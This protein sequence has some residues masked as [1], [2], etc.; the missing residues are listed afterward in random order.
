M[1]ITLNL[2]KDHLKLIPFILIKD[3]KDEV[4][5]IDKE[6]MLS[7]QSTLLEDVS[8]ILGLRDKAI[9]NTEFDANG[10]AFP[11]EIEEYM[12]NIYNYVKDNLYYIETLIHQFVI[13]GGI[14]EGVYEC[15]DKELLWFKKN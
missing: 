7:L 15:D 14:T 13:N 2:T 4:L 10:R 3:D 6:V 8:L 12:F 11:N 9:P 1:R 5:E